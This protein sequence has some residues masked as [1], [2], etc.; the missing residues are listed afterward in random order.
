[1]DGKAQDLALA[2]PTL[3][4]GGG[5][6]QSI[7]HSWGAVGASGAASLS[8]PLP[9][10]GGRSLAPSLSLDYSSQAGRS[11][12]G[13]GW[14]VGIPTIARRSSKGVPSYEEGDAIV[15]PNGDVLV[16]ERDSH[17]QLAIREVTAFRGVTLDEA[18]QVLRYFPR[19]EGGGMRF[20]SWRGASRR[21]WMLHDAGGTV[22]VYGR[23]AQTVSIDDGVERIAQ[24]WLEES[25]SANGEKMRY[26]YDREDGAGL[27]DDERARDHA[28]QLFLRR[29]LY[30]NERGD[31]VP[32]LLRPSDSTVWMFELLFDYGERTT[33]LDGKPTYAPA[34]PWP[35]RSDPFS[36]FVYG[37]E[38]RTLRLCRQ[39]LMFHRFPE[40]GADPVLVRRLLLE[41]DETAQVSYLVAAHDMAYDARGEVTFSPPLE[42]RYTRFA[43]PETAT[44][45]TFPELS[46]PAGNIPG[47]NDGTRYQ[48]VDLYGEGMAGVL[49][50][51]PGGWYYREPMRGAGGGD[52]VVY[53]DW[54]LLPKQPASPPG[55]ER[56]MALADLTGDGKLEW[57]VGRPGAG[58]Y[59]TLSPDRH[60]DQFVPFAALPAE[61]LGPRGQLVDLSGA[62]LS[63]F[64]VIGPRSVRWYPNA[65]QRGFAPPIDVPHDLDLDPLPGE[66]DGRGTLVAFGDLLGSGQQH[67]LRIRHDEVSVWPNLGRGRFG[68]RIA[69]A[70]LPFSAAQ[71]D[72]SRVRLADLDGSG[73]ADL[74][75]LESEQALIFMNR[76][77]HGFEPPVSLSWPEGVRF[78]RLC[79]VSIAD[80]Q[81]MGCSSLVLTVPHM[82]PRHWR[83]DFGRNAKP[84]MLEAT[85][86]N[87]GAQGEVDHRSSAQEW[88]DEKQTRRKNGRPAIS[89]LPFPVQVVTAQ[90]QIDEVTGQSLLQRFRYRGGYYDAH[91]REFR[92]FGKLIH[93]DTEMPVE[94]MAAEDG[95]TAPVATTTWFHVGRHASPDDEDFDTSDP[96]APALGPTLHTRYDA[97]TGEDVIGDAWDEDMS[98]QFA[99]ALSGSVKRVEVHGMD[100]GA[101]LPYSVSQHRYMLRVWREPTAEDQDAILQPFELESVACDYDRLPGDPRVTHTL[102]LRW[103]ARGAPVHAAVVHYSRR[104][105]APPF[106]EDCPRQWW[107]DSQDDAQFRYYVSETLAEWIHADDPQWWRSQLPYRSRGNAM[108]IP[109]TEL[110]A[111]DVCYERFIDPG[112]PLGAHRPRTLVQLSV[113]RYQGCADGEASFA[114]LPDYTET[115][116]LDEAA[117]EAYAE[118]MTPDERDAKLEELGY[119]RMS[120]FLP[121]ENAV[122]WSVQQGF[123]TFAPLDA[124]H[125]VLAYRLAPELGETR[126]D[127]DEHGLFVTRTTLPDGCATDAEYDYHTLLPH[128]IVDPNRNTQEAAYDAFGRVVATAFYGTEK[129]QPVG[130]APV[131]DHVHLYT[132][133]DE[134]LADPEGAIG[135]AATVSFYAP[136]AWMGQISPASLANAPE[137]TRWALPG[138]YVRASARWRLAAGEL[139]DDLAALVMQAGRHP[140]HAAV[141]LADRYP[142]DP[143]KQIRR[144]VV[145]SDGFGRALQQKHFVE[146]GEAY[147]T[148]ADGGLEL[149]GDGQPLKAPTDTR[150]RVSERVEYNNKGLPVRTYRPYFAD[151]HRYVRDEAFR[152]FG[153]CDRQHYDPLGRPTVTWTAAGWMRRRT[154]W[155]WYTIAEDEND[156]AEEVLLARAA[157][158]SG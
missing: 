51:A 149:D 13:Q 29:V 11:P 102:G 129:G 123:A 24:W 27:P 103:D 107:E 57:I 36:S 150:W 119:H 16:P 94:G 25:V 22:H 130:F 62:G 77:G 91:E 40:L 52:E 114:A 135:N 147:V 43:S 136:C 82:A 153:Y 122:L 124:F 15:A 72:A 34:N 28:N 55:Q 90:R 155:P 105:G 112:G 157:Q 8:I 132:L 71:F 126:A 42:C 104:R 59:F 148:N 125:R 18:Y 75:Y 97:A 100:D 158:A 93:Q 60:W 69:F 54:R 115:A 26:G 64:A 35:V 116:E 19:T 139:S 96:A 81:G 144:S 98:R 14:N 78:D 106:E 1:M 108:M 111:A 88:L 17:G 47:L 41:Y 66:G 84:H 79:E 2:P 53:D 80:L 152:E 20:E 85:N 74:I 137:D 49:H 128:R 32:D 5:A 70:S 83:C 151:T 3:P 7:G 121:A 87:M 142:G 92:G 46:T 134:A 131:S 76:S 33:A 101:T 44:F 67:L 143:E 4:K 50:P 73:A 156:T 9:I 37:F 145:D 38:V 63:D 56:R 110:V 23:A 146:P 133:P 120:A 68:K 141:L 113:Q 89:Y 95:F 127:Y 65:R 58:G 48:L 138:G 21:F 61:F 10:S 6:I 154:Y 140:P 39:V 30:G 117:L 31:W 99:R 12:F 109:D 45:S 118:V 86:N